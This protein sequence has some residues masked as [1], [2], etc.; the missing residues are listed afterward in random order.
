MIY[1]IVTL[2]VLTGAHWMDCDRLPS[3]FGRLTV[4]AAR[5]SSA[6]PKQKAVFLLPFVRKGMSISEVE[7]LLGDYPTYSFSH[8]RTITYEYRNF[9][10][11][12]TFIFGKVVY[13][14]P[15]P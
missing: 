8:G 12:V 5:H 10:V 11:T 14:S 2:V 6:S 4:L 13:A 3:I 7:K 15:C 9:G 1:S